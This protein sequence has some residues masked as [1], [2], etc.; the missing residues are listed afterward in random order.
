MNRGN[1]IRKLLGPSGQNGFVVSAFILILFSFSPTI[2][3]ALH[4]EA[5][6]KGGRE[7]ILEHG[8]TPDFNLYLSKM[9][10]GADGVWL[11]RELY[12]SEDHAPSLLQIFYVLLGKLGSSLGLSLVATYHAARLFLGAT[13]LLG[14]YYLATKLFPKS[15]WA[16]GA[17][18]LAITTSSWPIIKWS[19]VLAGIWRYGKYLGWWTIIDPT[20]RITITPHLLAGQTLLVFFVIGF[21]DVFKKGNL[22]KQAMLLG[23]FALVMGLVFPPA[24][25]LVYMIIWGTLG[26]NIRG[27][28]S[29]EALLGFIK[30]HRGDVLFAFIVTVISFPIFPYI[31]HLTS[32][33]P[34]K[35]LNDYNVLYPTYFPIHEFALA[36]GI[37]FI[38]ALGG[39]SIIVWK[40]LKE[41]EHNS[42]YE[43]FFPIIAWIAGIFIFMILIRKNPEQNALRFTQVVHYVPIGMLAAYFLQRLSQSGRKK[44]HIVCRWGTG[45][46][47]ALTIL[48]G[49]GHMAQ[50][51]AWQIDFSR[52]RVYAGYP[53]IP[54]FPQVVY[55]PKEF[56]DT[57][58][59]IDKNLPK[60]SVLLAEETFGN[61]I[62]AYTGRRV[63]CC[64]A[65]TP[66]VEGRRLNIWGFLW[67]LSDEYAKQLLKNWHVDYIVF[68]WQEK[69]QAAKA[70]YS[71]LGKR[72]TFLQRVYQ[73]GQVS[74]YKVPK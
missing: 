54:I 52:A 19:D 13:L 38:L 69:E 32:F 20:F 56:M 68:G 40:R 27:M 25:L 35:R 23:I 22:W 4:V 64:H 18:W 50:S 21:L 2:Y 34:W 57:L 9:R 53:Q 5:V 8:Y 28:S 6:E 7:L 70:G 61:Y 14:I 48:L 36:C 60:D 51:L 29:L 10:Q 3:E 45:I 66:D 24:L 41:K 47:F 44:F 73:N 33:Y 39:A 12:T 63:Y 58:R 71:D 1:F 37:A 55:P 59:F 49:V 16:L 72:Y 30:D 17:F 42:G 46:L 65:N 62:P 15:L 43:R 11:A 26:L 74:V 67:G 31:A